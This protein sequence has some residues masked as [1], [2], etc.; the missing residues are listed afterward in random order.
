MYGFYQVA[1]TYLIIPPL[2]KSNTK[3][4]PLSFCSPVPMAYRSPWVPSLFPSISV[5]LHTGWSTS[6]NKPAGLGTFPLRPRRTIPSLI[7]HP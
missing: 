7:T 4:H 2:S 1:F 5:C 6:A 3:T